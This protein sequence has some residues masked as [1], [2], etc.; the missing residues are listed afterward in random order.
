MPTRLLRP[1]LFCLLGVLGFVNGCA[2]GDAQPRQIGGLVGDG[3]AQN[4]CT[5][6]CGCV[7]VNGRSI[8][9][10]CADEL[11]KGSQSNVA[12]DRVFAYKSGSPP[13]SVDHSSHMTDVRDQATFGLC[14]AF[15]TVA[16][17]EAFLPGESS[18]PG[19]DLSELHAWSLY[20]RPEMVAAVTALSKYKIAPEPALPY[21]V[22]SE[23]VERVRD[24]VP[25]LGEIPA[26]VAARA[27]YGIADFSRIANDR[28]HRPSALMEVLARSSTTNIIFAMPFDPRFESDTPRPGT[29]TAQPD[30]EVPNGGHAILL[31]GYETIDGQL[32]FRFKN[33]WG[34]EW[35]DRG[36]GWLSAAY[37]ERMCDRSRKARCWGFYVNEIIDESGGSDEVHRCPD[38]Q[39]WD[40]STGAC[41]DLPQGQCP[42]NSRQIGDRYCQCDLGYVP[43]DLGQGCVP[44]AQSV[45]CG[46]LAFASVDDTTR[47]DCPAPMFWNGDDCQCPPGT[48]LRYETA[49]CECPAGTAWDVVQGGCSDGQPEGCSEAFRGDGICDGCL[50][51]DPDCAEP[52]EACPSEWRA[53]GTCDVCLGDDP[54]CAIP[55]DAC[56]QDGYCDGT[57]GN[58]PDCSQL[59]VEDGV[60]DSLNCINDPD[61][62]DPCGADA[63]CNPGCNQDPDC[64]CT[65]DCGARACGDDGCG[66]S[67]GDCQGDAFCDAAGQCQFGANAAVYNVN[68]IS[69][70][71]SELDSGGFCWDVPCGAFGPPDVRL[72][73]GVAGVRGATRTFQN[74]HEPE[75]G[76]VVLEAVAEEDLLSEIQIEA[77]DM[78]ALGG[79]GLI[80]S[81]EGS[82]D[83]AW[84]DGTVIEI[85][86][87]DYIVVRLQFEPL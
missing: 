77:W 76:A 51:D 81:C 57:C 14:T 6:R 85:Q 35:G 56:G 62:G 86:C 13:M 83:P 7:E 32:Y 26:S 46:G 17:I 39:I 66:G 29:L 34:E 43:D 80:G 72:E 4:A 42:P 63:Y 30:S 24:T 64:G 73:V 2:S 75:W 65:P 37:I 23:V 3:S 36:Y 45:Q 67:C 9:L 41:A 74:D 10:S 38:Q 78:D 79:N 20:Q 40:E 68:A 58:D 70:S 69:A 16:A 47:C 53:D 18:D 11:M 21:D 31:I 27:Y 22:H 82:V 28:L 19:R 54:D 15:A 8:P 33:S 49:S 52:V 12:E 87:G 5:A 50:G 59:C 1:L 61:C 44:S 48:L 25:T 71:V 60:C 55:E 84:L